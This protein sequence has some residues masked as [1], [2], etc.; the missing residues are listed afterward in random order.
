[1]RSS[2]KSS[3]PHQA[4]LKEWRR[5]GNLCGVRRANEFVRLNLWQVTC[6]GA[7]GCGLDGQGAILQLRGALAQDV[8]LQLQHM[9]L[10]RPR[11]LF[12]AMLQ[13]VGAAKDA[14]SAGPKARGEFFR[15]VRHL[16]V[17]TPPS[18]LGQ[19]L[20]KVLE[21]FIDQGGGEC[22]ASHVGSINDS[23]TFF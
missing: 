4:Y 3:S 23:D 17:V 21:S 13:G 11:Q 6:S 18:L 8:G 16:L 5:R 1:L 10:H 20:K 14:V 2:L 15:I 7:P 19:K 9:P 22:V 12:G